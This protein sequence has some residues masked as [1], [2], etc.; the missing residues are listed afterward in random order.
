MVQKRLDQRIVDLG[1]AI[2]RSQAS[3]DIKLGYVQVDG[4]TILKPG[5]NTSDNQAISISK[6]NNYVSR[7]ALKLET[8][9]QNFQLNFNNLTI[10]DVGSSTGG[11]TDFSL[12]HGAKRIFAVDVGTNQMHPKLRN[13]RRIELFEKTDIRDFDLLVKPDVILI[14]VSFISF[15]NIMA[16]IY[17]FSSRQTLICLMAK[18]QFESSKDNLINGIVKNENIR[19]KILKELELELKLKFKVINK[20]DS[21]VSGKKGNV[22]RFYL[23]KKI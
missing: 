17:G 7:A 6:V 21:T 4:K 5:F 3:S 12:Q 15:K 14:D 22:E 19:R 13:D 16:K 20:F 11:F 10:L 1:L 2:S 8:A 23:L 18:P 9:Y